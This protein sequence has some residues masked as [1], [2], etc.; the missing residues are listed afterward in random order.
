MRWICPSNYCYTYMNCPLEESIPSNLILYCLMYPN[1]PAH[2]NQNFLI[3]V[4]WI[5][6][7]YVLIYEPKWTRQCDVQKYLSY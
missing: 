4:S 2:E 7:A 6:G 5:I 3:L 1:F